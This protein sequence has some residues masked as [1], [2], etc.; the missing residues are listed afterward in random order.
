[1]TWLPFIC[2]AI[3][4][5]IGIQKLSA[6]F[7]V[8]VDQA[9]TVTLVLLMLV[10][11]A[12]IGINPQVMAKLGMV[13]FNCAV[14]ALLAITCS[15]LFVFLV[16]KTILPLEKMQNKLFS[17]QLNIRNEVD[18]SEQENQKTSHLVWI[19]PGSIM[20]GIV[21]GFFILPKTSSDGLSIALTFLLIALYIGV[22]ISLGM[23]KNVFRYVKM[24]GWKIIFLAIA[25]FLGSVLAGVIGGMLLEIPYA[26][27]VTSVSGMSY[28]SITGAFMTSVYGIE[29]G[30]YGFIV[31]VMRE[32]FTVLMIPLLIQISKGSPIA[33]GAAG[34]MDTMLAPV[35]KFVGAELGLVALITGT[36][37]TFA[38]PFILPFL[39]R[40]FL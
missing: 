6:Y 33:G 2:L 20:L 22:G 7:L 30:T 37:L 21:V 27:S 8:L 35:T 38:V 9:I 14:L 13:G 24:L 36:I 10:I 26:I 28:Y 25:I 17:D 23:N 32:F 19:M 34:N 4:F 1:M 29:A 5:I 31:N 40:I 39:Y 18:L 16:E 12:S 3:G 11:G 15:I